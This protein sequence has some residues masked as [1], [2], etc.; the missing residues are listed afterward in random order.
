MG[1]RINELNTETIAEKL[2]LLVDQQ[3]IS[4]DIQSTLESLQEEN[5]ANL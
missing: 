4:P 1:T 5:D 3:S 2:A